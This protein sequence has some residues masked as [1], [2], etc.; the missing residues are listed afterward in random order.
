MGL[1]LV[2]K[3]RLVGRDSA[4]TLDALIV[5]FAAAY[6]GWVYLVVPYYQDFGEPFDYRLIAI[7]DPLGDLLLLGMLLRLIISPGSRN[8]ALWL[9]GAGALFQTA[10][11]LVESALR[12]NSSDW[13]ASHAGNVLLECAWLLFA[14]FWVVAALVPSS[15]DLTR[16]VRETARDALPT[17]WS[18]PP[19]IAP[20]VLAA[21]VTPIINA[22]ELADGNLSTGWVGP[23]IG[24]GVYLMIL[25]R[26]AVMVRQHRQALTRESILLAASEGLGVAAGSG[27]VAAAL[28]D[29]AAGLFAGRVAAHA[30]LVAVDGPEGVRVA[31]AGAVDGGA[32]DIRTHVPSALPETESALWRAMLTRVCDVRR[33]AL[34]RRE[35]GLQRALQQRPVQ[36]RV[37]RRRPLEQRCRAP[38]RD[39]AARALPHAERRA[40]HRPAAADGPAAGTA[41]AHRSR[42][43]GRRGRHP[44]RRRGRGGPGGARRGA[45]DPGP[46]GVGGDWSGSR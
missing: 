43:A 18:R 4:G 26:V 15:H 10:A 42:A 22:V 2:M 27:Q 33:L 5:V 29:G 24:L 38:C 28:A 1:R 6:A 13:F 16:P 8:A 40:H 9:L 12:L 46:A 23:M 30:V 34:P 44:A 36:R 20:L 35:Q 39:D 32:G 19:R 37:L 7:L 11:D 21:L 41:G 17:A 45:G 25:A 31:A 3:H 14:A